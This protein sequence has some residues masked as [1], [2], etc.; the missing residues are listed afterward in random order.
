MVK[1]Q[2]FSSVLTIQSTCWQLSHGMRPDLGGMGIEALDQGYGCPIKWISLRIPLVRYTWVILGELLQNDQGAAKIRNV[3]AGKGGICWHHSNFWASQRLLGIF[4][5]HQSMHT[6]KTTF[7]FQL[8]CEPCAIPVSSSIA[9]PPN[10][11][12]AL[13]H[14]LP[15]RFLFLDE[16]CRPLS[17]Q[18][19]FCALV[20]REGRDPLQD[21]KWQN[22]NDSSCNLQFHEKFTFLQKKSLSI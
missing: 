16:T 1:L 18:F 12:H 10:A 4:H 2:G 19:N 3:P 21:C 13:M 7:N 22:G 11:F 8:P 9:I 6:Y 15:T 20:D 17:S 5:Y 14:T